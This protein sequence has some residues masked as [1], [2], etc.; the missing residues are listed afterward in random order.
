M[1]I[2]YLKWYLTFSITRQNKT[3]LVLHIFYEKSKK[4]KTRGI[5]SNPINLHMNIKMNIHLDFY[6]SLIVNIEPDFTNTFVFL[7]TYL[8]FRSCNL[9]PIHNNAILL[10]IKQ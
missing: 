2:F 9:H 8:L 5:T 6:H 4:K 7:I 1:N 10:Q 3:K